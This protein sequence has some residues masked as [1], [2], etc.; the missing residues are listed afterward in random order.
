MEALGELKDLGG[1][2]HNWR[3]DLLLLPP[4]PAEQTAP[5]P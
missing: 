3:G 1:R 5:A 2:A 4:K